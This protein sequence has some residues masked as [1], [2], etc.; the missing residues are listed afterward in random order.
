MKIEMW[1]PIENYKGLYLVSS[2]GRVMNAKTGRILK[3]QKNERGYIK[4]ELCKDGKS[5]LYSLHRLVLIA[6]V[7]YVEGKDQVRHIDGDKSNC[8]LDNLEWSTQAENMKHFFN[9]NT[10][11]NKRRIRRIR[12]VETKE[13]Y[14]NAEDA[15]VKLGYDRSSI[16]RTAQGLYESLYGYHF[17][18]VD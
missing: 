8:E 2:L 14:M 5:K 16:L 3:P 12:C 6:F 13:V 7:G 4:V 17:E 15:S 10:K 9:R 18:F 1:K 11:R